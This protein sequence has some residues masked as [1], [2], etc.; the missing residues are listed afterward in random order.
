[1]LAIGKKQ[2]YFFNKE[3]K[4]NIKKEFADTKKFNFNHSQ[5]QG[6]ICHQRDEC[7]T[8]S[9]KYA[10]FWSKMEVFIIDLQSKDF[11]CN[12]LTGFIPKENSAKNAI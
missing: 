9:D 12:M 6:N 4:H 2:A 10:I 8:L 1:L 11:K 3:V 5:S 7:Y